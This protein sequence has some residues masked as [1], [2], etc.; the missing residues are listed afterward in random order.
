MR[1]ILINP[2]VQKFIDSYHTRKWNF[3]GNKILPKNASRS[4]FFCIQQSPKMY[5]KIF[6]KKYKKQKEMRKEKFKCSNLCYLKK[7]HTTRT[8]NN[9][10]NTETP[11]I[12]GNR[13]LRK[14][15]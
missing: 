3:E 12:L 1:G 15:E 11:S 8:K 4:H 7:N 13:L 6:I 10:K 14:A 5:F 2:A 9:F